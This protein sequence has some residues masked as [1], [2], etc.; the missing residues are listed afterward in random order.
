MFSYTPVIRRIGTDD[1]LYAY[2]GSIHKPEIILDGEFDG[3]HFVIISNMNGWPTAY[4]SVNDTDYIAE[5]ELD[6]DYDS[7]YDYLESVHG[8]GT[9]YGK[10]YW[11]PQDTRTYVGWD[12]AHLGDYISSPWATSSDRAGHK[13][14]IDEILVSCI[15]AI[16][17]LRRQNY[18][19]RK[20]NFY[21][22]NN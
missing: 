4:V 19:Y 11:D 22:S 2:D 16:A 1:D 7:R 13:Y 20:G 14:T 12:Y 9:Y 8:G 3:R 10:A 18:E 6:N 17:E 21:E 15:L 5:R